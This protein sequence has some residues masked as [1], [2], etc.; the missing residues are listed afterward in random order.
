MVGE[1]KDNEAHPE[2]E[3]DIDGTKVVQGA[4]VFRRD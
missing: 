3:I 1:R 4:E 2:T